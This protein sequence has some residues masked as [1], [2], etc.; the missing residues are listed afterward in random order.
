MKRQTQTINVK[1]KTLK[2]TLKFLICWSWKLP[3]LRCLRSWKWFQQNLMT[4][5][6]M[7]SSQL[8]RELCKASF[9]EALQQH[10]ANMA[11]LGPFKDFFVYV[12]CL[13]MIF[14][15]FSCHL[16]K[17]MSFIF[18]LPTK[19]VQNTLLHIVP[20]VFTRSTQKP[21]CDCISIYIV[22]DFSFK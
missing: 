10:D 7:G 17:S 1:L 4:S 12:Q 6:L 9:S 11:V 2:L 15:C 5:S 21:W 20:T 3:A 16:L 14:H 22:R 8:P 19:K 18:C 13:W